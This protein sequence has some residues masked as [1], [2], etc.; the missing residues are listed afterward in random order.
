MFGMKYTWGQNCNK[1]QQGFT[2]IELLVVISIIVVL[3]A[4]ILTAVFNARAESRDMARATTTE[5]LKLAVRLYKD[6]KGVYPDYAEGT[7]IASDTALGQALLP[8]IK[9]FKD[10]SMREEG[11]EYWY[12]SDFDCTEPGQRVVYISPLERSENSN[13]VALCG[14]DIG[15]DTNAFITIITQ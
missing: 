6:A 12:I 4:G 10:D 7:E 11:F 3:G 5:Q 2:L 1:S 15:A 13:A 9:G 14:A 8:Y